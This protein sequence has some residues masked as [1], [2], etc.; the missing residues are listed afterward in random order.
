MDF[1]KKIEN[2]TTINSK[3]VL[4]QTDAIVFHTLLDLTLRASYRHP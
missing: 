2:Q 4:L 1:E 3:K